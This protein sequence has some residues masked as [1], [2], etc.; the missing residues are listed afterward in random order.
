MNADISRNAPCPCGSGM[1]YK[2][3][4]GKVSRQA[5]KGGKT[6]QAQALNQIT[7]VMRTM[8]PED[9]GWRDIQRFVGDADSTPLGVVHPESGEVVRDKHRVTDRVEID[10][11]RD[12]VIALAAR[13]YQEMVEKAYGIEI[14]WFEEPQILRYHPGGFYSPHSDRDHL[15]PESKRWVHYLDRDF[16]ILIYLDDDYQG[17]ELEFPEVPHTIQP[18][19]GMVLGFPADHRFVHAAKPV[20]SGIRHAVVSWAAAVG[21]PRVNRP[22]SG[23]VHQIPR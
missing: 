8:M 9:W 16:S 18:K 11:I 7:S 3:C 10:P 6:R 17:G 19:A 12:E 23:I 22:G 4:C 15:D 13:V 21:G 2:H 5:R 1:K 20:R 14:E